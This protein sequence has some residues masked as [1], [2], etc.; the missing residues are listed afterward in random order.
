[1]ERRTV[2]LSRVEILILDEAD[3]MLDMGFIHDV[4]RIINTLPG[5]RQTLLFSATMPEEIKDLARSIQRKPRYVE[6]GRQGKPATTITQSFYAVRRDSKIDL[7][8]HVVGA[9]KMSSVLVFSRTK[10]GADK[11]T[12]RLERHGLKAVAIHSNRTQAQRQRALD[13][14]KAGRFNILVATDIAARGI[15]IDNVSHVINFDTPV[16]AEDYVH[17]I[18]RTGRAEAAGTA[19]TFV[20]PEEQRLVRGIER[21]VGR[22]LDIRE[23]PDFTPPARPSLPPGPSHARTPIKPHHAHRGNDHK[24]RMALTAGRK[25]KPAQKLESFSTVMEG[26]AT[27]Q[28][29]DWKKLLAAKERKHTSK[30]WRNH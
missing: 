30:A 8:V 19:L 15:D 9:E 25:R 24:K 12:R 4:R 16:T 1:M 7:L 13:G 14:F 22:R 28:S 6:V 21:V 5:E 17:R 10:H 3:R 29:F 2:D 20:S 18:G 26:G 27:V 23:Y 11:I